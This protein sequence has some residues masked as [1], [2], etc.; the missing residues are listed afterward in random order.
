MTRLQLCVTGRQQW[1]VGLELRAARFH[2][3]YQTTGLHPDKTKA[4]KI[5]P[6]CPT[7]HP[8]SMA[9]HIFEALPSRLIEL[10]EILHPLPRVPQVQVDLRARLCPPQAE[11]TFPR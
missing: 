5:N 3:L 8:P 7:R 1:L 2:P 9:S 10:F 6:R 11:H 4:G